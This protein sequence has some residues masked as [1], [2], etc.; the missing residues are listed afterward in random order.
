[1]H[2]RPPAIVVVVA[3]T[4][5]EFSTWAISKKSLV[6][7]SRFKA[8]LIPPWWSWKEMMKKKFSWP[9][10]AP[11]DV[12]SASIRVL[13]PPH[14]KLIGQFQTMYILRL[15]RLRSPRVVETTWKLEKWVFDSFVQSSSVSFS[16]SWDRQA[17]QSQVLHLFLQAQL[18]RALLL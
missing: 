14:L 8:V 16:A 15:M 6:T 9:N 13:G 10:C 11:Q 5:W 2:A 1:M 7:R 3:E 12:I 4:R 18:P 17:A